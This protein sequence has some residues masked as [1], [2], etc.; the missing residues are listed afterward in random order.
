M[1][2]S[3]PDD[4]EGRN[5]FF[6]ACL[7]LL[8]A[9]RRLDDALAA[10]IPEGAAEAESSE[11]GLLAVLGAVAFRLRIEEALATSPTRDHRPKKPTHT[12]GIAPETPGIAPETPGLASETP[13]LASTATER[14]PGLRDILR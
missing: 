8:S 14:A 11:P 10:E 1:L 5:L 6:W 13:D 2:D 4:F 12:P 7:G 9:S 3:R